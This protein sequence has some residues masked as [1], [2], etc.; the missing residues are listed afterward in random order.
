MATN[1]QNVESGR[2]LWTA[3]GTGRSSLSLCW[4]LWSLLSVG[5]TGVLPVEGSGNGQRGHPGVWVVGACPGW[6]CLSKASGAPVRLK[7]GDGGQE[8]VPLG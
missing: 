2:E 5:E 3:Q 1:S 6:C 8:G 7:G 4:A